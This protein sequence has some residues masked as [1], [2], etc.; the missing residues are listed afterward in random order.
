MNR[1]FTR[2]AGPALVLCVAAAPAWAD[3]RDDEIARLR[4][5][6]EEQAAEQARMRAQLDA[7]L[8]KQTP[9][10]GGSALGAA[11]DDL[12]ANSTP[13]G[14]LFAQPTGLGPVRSRVEIGGYF[15]T[16]YRNLEADDRYGSFLDSRLVFLAKADVTKKISFS[17]EI[18][19]E[20]GGISDEL[21]GEI[22]VEQA[23]LRFKESDCFTF[24]AGTLLV[25]WGRFNLEH[26]D[27]LNELSSRPSV[28]RFV[29][30]AAFAL[31]G[32]GVEGHLPGTE[33]L[34]LSYDIVLTNGLK[35][36]ILSGDGIRDA[37]GLFEDDD[38]HGK[39]AFGRFGMVP[40]VEFV[41]ALSL[42][43]SFAWGNVGTEGRG[44][45]DLRGYGFDLAAKDGPWEVK[46]EWSHLGIDRADGTAP[47]KD[48]AGN[49]G[50]VRGLGGWYGQVA[51]RI[52]DPWV[53]S[54]PFAEDS[55]SV[56]LVLRRDAIDLNDRV[57]GAAEPDDERAWSFGI[58]YRPTTR[59]VIK[60]EYRKAESGF[61]G[62][63]GKDRDLI[64]L[65]FATYF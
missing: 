6:V 21:D 23:T 9:D 52:T 19:F 58:N 43:A 27:P 65:E 11:I 53:R 59:T 2:V 28:S 8:S 33:S 57:R 48:A 1:N 16:V 61:D 26:D 49:I 20:H 30:G 14:S 34:A 41:E 5:Q 10:A 31:P 64:A 40:D 42:G 44:E 3:E 54:M 45:H 7:I 13:A 60:L 4:R 47:P 17:T 18:E 56:A 24:K 15:S 29:N 37:R 46:G 55:A 62:E 12:A 32:V 36:E 39:T 38:N 50:P 25:P 63:E 22:K 51:Y 35:D